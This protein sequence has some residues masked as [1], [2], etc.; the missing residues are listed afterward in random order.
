MRWRRLLPQ[1]PALRIVDIGSGFGGMVMSPGK[2][3]GPDCTVIGVELAPLPCWVASKLMA[4]LSSASR[5]RFL[6]GDYERL[7]F[8]DYDVVFAYLS[9]AAMPALWAK[10]RTRNAPRHAAAQLRI[11][12][13]RRGVAIH[14]HI[15]GRQAEFSMA[16]ICDSAQTCVTFVESFSSN[17]VAMP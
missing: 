17:R 16:G 8:A 13:S 14:Q 12:H 15:A 10:A 7:D 6:H 4:M 5:G 9:P 2:R 1:A 3:I 11:R